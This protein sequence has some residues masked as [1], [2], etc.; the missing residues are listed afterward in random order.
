[1]FW[2][3]ILQKYKL[4]KLAK[5]LTESVKAILGVINFTKFV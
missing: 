2:K 4:A 5:T 1:M 3:K